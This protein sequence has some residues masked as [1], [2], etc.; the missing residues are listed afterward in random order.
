ML[1]K[2][3]EDKDKE[4][5]DLSSKLHTLSVESKSK[6]EEF[7]NIVKNY[8]TL[9]NF[10]KGSKM[11]DNILE[12][13]RTSKEKFGL[14]FDPTKTLDPKISRT[15][16]NHRILFVK[17]SNPKS[18]LNS[19]KSSKLRLAKHIVKDNVNTRKKSPHSTL[20]Y[21]QKKWMTKDEL[22]KYKLVRNINPIGPKDIWVPKHLSV[23]PGNKD[24]NMAVRQ[25]VYK[26][27]DGRQ[28]STIQRGPN[29]WPQK[30]QVRR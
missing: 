17:E 24:I 22:G 18:L 3:L 9:Q 12:N 5:K 16:K 7:E 29:L 25:R 15:P 1:T 19:K 21:S 30:G 28:R 11:L 2:K 4:I 13:S 27:H 6:N 8:N 26:T 14:G 23:S 20:L 10:T